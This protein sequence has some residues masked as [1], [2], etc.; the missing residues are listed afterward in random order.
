MDHFELDDITA[1]RRAGTLPEFMRSR[2]RRPDAVRNAGRR[3]PRRSPYGAVGHKPGAW[4]AAAPLG[5]DYRRGPGEPELCDCAR[6]RTL[7]QLCKDDPCRCPVCGS[8]RRAAA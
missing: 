6:C 3:R 4:P 5:A 8:P 7:A 1:M 2:I